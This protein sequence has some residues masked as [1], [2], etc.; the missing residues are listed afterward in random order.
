MYDAL[1]D[2]LII[3]FAMGCEA[4][5]QSIF[6]SESMAESPCPMHRVWFPIR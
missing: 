2:F 4:V 5:T 6:L 1:S 3:V